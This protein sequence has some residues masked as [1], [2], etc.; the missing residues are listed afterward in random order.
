MSAFDVMKQ[1]NEKVFRDKTTT[2]A[3]IDITLRNISSQQET[4]IYKLIGDMKGTEF[5]TILKVKTLVQAIVKMNDEGFGDSEDELKAK[6][7]VINNWP[8]TLVDQLYKVYSELCTEI[9]VD[10]GFIKPEEEDKEN[11]DEEQA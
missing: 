8:S 3:G 2:I 5:F 4:D 10:L 6:E 11:T 1:L 7:E 9:D